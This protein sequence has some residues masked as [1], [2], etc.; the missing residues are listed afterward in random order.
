MRHFEQQLQ[1]LLKKLV[2]MGSIAEAMIQGAVRS[3]IERNE[4]PISAV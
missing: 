1:D 3:L 4:S 2:L